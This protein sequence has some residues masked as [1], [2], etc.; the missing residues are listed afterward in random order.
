MAKQCIIVDTAPHVQQKASWI[1][2]LET[3]VVHTESL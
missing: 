3:I 1:G 2:D